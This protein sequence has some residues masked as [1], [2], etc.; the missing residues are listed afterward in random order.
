VRRPHLPCVPPADRCHHDDLPPDQ[1]DAVALGQ[2]AGLHH[3]V[4]LVQRERALRERDGHRVLS[5][6]LYV[7]GG[8]VG[9]PGGPSRMRG[10][11]HATQTGPRP[12]RGA[13][14]RRPGRGHRDPERGQPGFEQAPGAVTG[15]YRG[16]NLGQRLIRPRHG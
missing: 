16:E 3:A 2:D 5:G 12:V 4:V 14:R 13:G 11:R 6:P 7:I 1:L 8:R 9:G 10:T 15:L